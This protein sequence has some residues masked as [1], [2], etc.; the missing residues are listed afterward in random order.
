MSFEV[1][2]AGGRAALR[3]EWLERRRV[4]VQGPRG[5]AAQVSLG[6]HLQAVLATL[7]P[8]CL[9]GYWAM[10][11]EFNAVRLLRDDSAGMHW[12]L[13]LPFARREGRS[14]HYRAWDGA[15]PTRDDE[16]GIPTSDGPE[17]LPDVVL[18]PCLG[19][20]RDGYRLGY[21]AGYFDRFLAA[22]PHLTAVGVAWSAGELD[23]ATGFVPQPHDR[24]L[25][26]I[27]TED[28]VIG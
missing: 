4:F 12:P 13:A 25:T 7:E 8:Q 27:V 16:C 2:T 26:L 6:N 14:M 10:R 19:H 17:V 9:G 15:A 20:T 23:A 1:P 22:H 11:S 24:P 28:G 21:G 18:V 3:K 5:A